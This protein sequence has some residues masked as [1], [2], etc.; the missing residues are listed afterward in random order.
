M[1]KLIILFFGSVAE[2]VNN[3]TGGSSVPSSTVPNMES[4]EVVPHINPGMMHRIR[5]TTDGL[6][7]QR[8][9]I[10]CPNLFLNV[11]ARE[12][13]S[14]GKRPC[15]YDQAGQHNLNWDSNVHVATGSVK[16]YSH[17]QRRR[18]VI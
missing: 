5:V 14:L 11:S 12:S 7:R 17:T 15:E 16:Q 6:M 8:P 3:R 2:A 4:D 1:P 13:K 10:N 9:D 18:G